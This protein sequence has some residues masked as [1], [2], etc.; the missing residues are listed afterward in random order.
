MLPD[1]DFAFLGEAE[2]GVCQLLECL[3]LNSSFGLNQ[4]DNLVWRDQQG[5]VICNPRVFIED[6]NQLPFPAWE[7]INPNDYPLAPIGVFSQR[8]NVAPIIATRG[9]PYPCSFC[10]A[11]KMSGKKIRSR[12]ADNIIAEIEMLVDRFGV[13]EINIIDDNFTMKYDLVHDF[14]TT[15]IERNIGIIWSCP[16]G[17]RLDTLD[18]DL[19]RLM[20]KSGC[21][22]FGV[23]IEFGTQKMLD[24]VQKH[25]S[26]ETIREKVRLIK[27]VTRI[28]VTGF[29]ILGHPKEN[30]ADV[31][32]TI[33]FAC[34]L[35]IDRANFFNYSPFPGSADYEEL[36]LSGCDYSSLYDSLYINNVVYTPK[37][38]SREKLVQLQRKAFFRFF[39]RPR[40]FINILKET[41]SISQ[42][43]VLVAKVLRLILIPEKL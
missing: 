18:E 22:S 31:E 25:L 5:K 2:H 20:E 43:R 34:S 36:K 3:Q 39:L 42:F 19:L 16:N 27:S 12:S 40:I 15:L 37:N 8:N 35:P 10:A 1:I 7:L 14:C 9:C 11:G 38:I 23:G 13:E 33:D 17:I 24:Q 21:Y 29:F 26:L 4:V 28:R 30:L 32:Q 41:R 6:L